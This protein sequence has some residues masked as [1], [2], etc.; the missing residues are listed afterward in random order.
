[1][2]EKDVGNGLGTWAILEL[3]GHVKL[4]GFVTEEERFGTKVGRIDI[5]GPNDSMTTQYFG[6]SSL[7]R[8]T[9]CTEDVARAYAEQNQPRPV[10][11]FQLRLPETAVDEDDDDFDF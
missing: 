8:M 9:P 5:P 4:G 7:Y 6:G 2:A 11:L 3:M 10:W 1:M